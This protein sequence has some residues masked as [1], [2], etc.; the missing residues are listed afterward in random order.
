M[1]TI[2]IENEELGQIKARLLTEKNPNTCKTIYEALPMELHSKR[3]GDCL[4]SFT[5]KG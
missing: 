3:W 5:F 4:Y 1:S 2:I